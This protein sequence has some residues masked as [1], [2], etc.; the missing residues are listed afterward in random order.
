MR[1]VVRNAVRTAALT[2]TLAAAL[3]P[4]TGVA[5]AQEQPPVGDGM[6]EA[7][8]PS[9]MVV[10]VGRLEG[11]IRS[12]TGQIEQLQYQNRKLED[13]LRK[14]QGDVEFRFQDLQ[15]TGA[16]GAP[17][18]RPVAPAKRGDADGAP[19]SA[20]ADGGISPQP[21]V[22]EAPRSETPRAKIARGDAFDPDSDPD[23]PG[24]PRPLGST[25][26][27]TPLTP[28][29]VAR[30]DDQHI[31]LD[32]MSKPGAAAAA[33]GIEIAPQVIPAP[34]AATRDP[35]AVAS[36]VP[37]G[38]REEYDADL[39]LYKQG[40]FDGAASG[41][42]AFA[43]KYPRDFPFLFVQV[44]PFSG[45]QPDLREAQLLT[46]KAAPRTAMAVTTDLGDANNI[47]PT[48][49]G[50]VGERLELAARALAYGEKIE[51]SGPL[52]DAAR[53]EGGRA[54]LTFTH[55]EHGLVAKDGPL[56]GF[57]IAGADKKFVPADAVING[58]TL[59]VTSPMVP[60]PTAVR[61]G[62]V[63][64]PDVNLFNTEGLPASPFRTDVE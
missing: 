10:R 46:L 28:R 58:K 41:F 13:D 6:D 25:A 63:N 55:D 15:R 36:L 29:G 44:A 31:P 4:S 2:V 64:A 27:S 18:I 43:A 50:P 37:G 12:L 9:A 23:A 34:S 39:G 47:H 33:A 38:T 49:K 19:A 57:L 17:A 32:L 24:A 42:Q 35:T 40:Q 14:M 22:A 45:T 59:V 30:S 5:W 48:H 62:Y 16:G 26:P 20:V 8:D 3:C 21:P 7:G 56:K 51:Y 53:F 11:Q 60:S 61:Y 1:S 52:F 54:V